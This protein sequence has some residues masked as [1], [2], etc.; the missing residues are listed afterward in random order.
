MQIFGATALVTGANRGIGR[1][2]AAQLVERGAAT[3]YATARRPESVDLPG[4]RVLPLDVTDPDSVAAAAAAT[5]DVTL[6]VNNAG[7]TTGAD[8]VGGDLG[9]IRQEMDTHFWGTLHMIRAFAPQ[10]A[11]G[12]I[13][14]V[15]SAL[16]W[17]AYPGAG[18]YAA[19]KAA[20]WNLT[21]AV[22]LELAAQ[23]TQ[24]T[25]LLMGAVDTDMMASYDGPKS[26]PAVIVKAALDGLEAGEWEVLAD[27]TA[28]AVKASLAADPSGGQK[29]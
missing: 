24:V 5:G 3:V 29:T 17:S 8:L 11:N 6:L 27:E 12:A 7:V 21:N 22:R 18:G 1:H 16:S 4:V 13:L 28:R 14:N 9:L 20:E 2:F 26:D 10:L 15:L 23:H 25:G 19:A